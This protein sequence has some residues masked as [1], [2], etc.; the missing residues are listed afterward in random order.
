MVISFLRVSPQMTDTPTA[1]QSPL[2]W[3][4]NSET[5]SLNEF[6]NLPVDREHVHWPWYL[7]REMIFPFDSATPLQIAACN[8]N[9]EIA[10]SLIDHGAV[11]NSIDFKCVTPLHAASATGQTAML[12]LLLGSGANPNAVDKDLQTPCM[13]AASRGHLT[14]V[15]ILLREGADLHSKDLY[16]CTALHQAIRVKR[17]EVVVF[18][19]CNILDHDLGFEDGDANST[20]CHALMVRPPFILNYAAN[21]N[22][23]VPQRGNI[24]SYAAMNCDSIDLEFLLRRLP[25]DLVPEL[26]R[27]RHQYYGTPLYAAATGAHQEGN[28]EILIKAG[29]DSEQEGGDYGTPLIG[30]CAAGR[31][32]AVK[33]LVAKEAQISYSKDGETV[34]AIRAAKHQPEIVR[35]LL[36]GRFMEAPR[37]IMAAPRLIM[38]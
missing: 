6:V 21:P 24:L 37:L 14:C 11:V 29:A 2:P 20:L 18:L 16:G 36:V 30:A 26:L 17:L 13:L 28:M 10:R 7:T 12:D 32:T 5:L 34:S 22:A 8:D 19:L 27:R 33:M 3:E 1:K 35:W 23:Y 38:A 9:I 25:K 31:L 4:E 15:Q